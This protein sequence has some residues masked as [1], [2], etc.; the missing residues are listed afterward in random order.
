MGAVRPMFQ[1]PAFTPYGGERFQTL[2][3]TEVMSSFAIGGNPDASNKLYNYL[4]P[5]QVIPLFLA[6]VATSFALTWFGKGAHLPRIKISDAM[7]DS[8]IRDLSNRAVEVQDQTATLFTEDLVSV[9]MFALKNP[10]VVQDRLKAYMGASVLGYVG[11][12]F[13]QGVQE[14]M[15]RKEETQIRADLIQHLTDNFRKSIQYKTAMDNQLRETAKQRISVILKQCNIPYPEALLKPIQEPTQ[16]RLYQYPYEPYH[17]SKPMQANPSYRFG[18][19]PVLGYG[20]DTGPD[21]MQMKVMK[22]GI[23]GLGM[24]TGGLGQFMMALM[25]AHA[26]AP[27]LN[28]IGKNAKKMF[29]RIFNVSNMEALFLSEKSGPILLTVL[30]LT[31]AA[32]LGKMLVDGYREIEV[33]RQNAHTELRYQTHNWLS[34]DPSFH[35]IS[36]EEALK[37][38]LAK[39]WEAIPYEYNNRKALAQRIQTI[40][41]NVGRNSAPKY[42]QMTPPVSLVAARG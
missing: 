7:K 28:S 12:S 16:D 3:P 36:E 38:G 32:K 8:P 41:T 13:A 2:A 19:G 4:G 21:P 35:R 30:A 33:T 25:K 11:G 10:G 42:F 9:L 24:V 1:S 14:V 5:G 37:D 29:Y 18:N 31:C 27:E 22:G 6:G 34:L 20:S 15:V 39:L 23:F 40:L 26:D 17:F